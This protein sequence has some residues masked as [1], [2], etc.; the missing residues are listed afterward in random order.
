MLHMDYIAFTLNIHSSY[1]NQNHGVQHP[2][3]TATSVI[4]MI[5]ARRS[6]GCD[7]YLL[8]NKW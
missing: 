2:Q 6:A 4:F 8:G 7:D 3:V 5:L 1:L